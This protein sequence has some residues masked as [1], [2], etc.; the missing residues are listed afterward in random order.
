M[1]QDANKQSVIA[2]AKREAESAT[3]NIRVEAREQAEIAAERAK[4]AAEAKKGLLIKQVRDVEVALQ[5]TADSLD[6]EALGNQLNALSDRLGQAAEKMH[7]AEIA[8][9]VAAAGDLS[10][11]YPRTFLGVS[12]CLGLALARFGRASSPERRRT[13]N[14]FRPQEP[15]LNSASDHLLAE[16]PVIQTPQPE[17]GEKPWSNP[18]LAPKV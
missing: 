6:N 8:E 16:N 9:L 12:F 2:R 11:S 7:R 4:T 14:E 18:R 5:Q 1:S 13:S 17:T 3:R 15:S 10:R